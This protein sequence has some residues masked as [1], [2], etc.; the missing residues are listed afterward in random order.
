[1]KQHVVSAN[2]L[3]YWDYYFGYGLIAAAICIIEAALLWA[4]GSIATTNAAVVRPLLAILALWNLAHAIVVL[5][6]FRFP[7]PIAF[8]LI[9]AL[10]LVW[11]LLAAGQTA[12]T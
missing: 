2:N 1:M 5:R 6:Y 3:S 4:M 12:R 10:C 11:A 7:V 9:I 8:D